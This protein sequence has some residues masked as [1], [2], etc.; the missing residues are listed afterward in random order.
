MPKV[1][2]TLNDETFQQ[3]T[4]YASQEGMEV[5]EFLS[6]EIHQRAAQ[7]LPAAPKAWMPREQWDALV[8]GEQ[9]P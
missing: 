5:D 3:F 4:G 7:V 8:R 9:C 2:L 1:T 6:R